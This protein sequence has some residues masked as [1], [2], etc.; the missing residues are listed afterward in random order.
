MRVH[1]H[2]WLA[3]LVATF[4]LLLAAAP[5]ELDRLDAQV[6]IPEAG[7]DTPTVPSLVAESEPD[8]SFPVL[9]VDGDCE[10]YRFVASQVWPEIDTPAG[11]SWGWVVKVMRRESHC[12]ADPPGSNDSGSSF[13]L[14]QVHLPWRYWGK[15]IG[16]G[17]GPINVECHL[18]AREDLLNPATNLACARVLY[19]ARGRAPWA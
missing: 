18:T 2:R 14:M 11:P 12:L 1:A 15:P 8:Q 17:Y 4:T 7:A 5:A 9:Y 3:G 13:G 19:L 10:S 6:S 16:W